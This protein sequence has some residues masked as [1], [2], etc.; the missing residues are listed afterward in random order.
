MKTLDCEGAQDFRGGFDV[1]LDPN[2]FNSGS[3]LYGV[4][5]AIIGYEFSSARLI[6]V[7]NQPEAISCIGYWSEQSG[8]IAEV[9][10]S[11]DGQGHLSATFVSSKLYGHS[12]SK[13]LCEVK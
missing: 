12:E 11:K 1:K 7:G 9:K 4:G 13:V 3:G 8:D 10:T 6:C 5:E 2:V